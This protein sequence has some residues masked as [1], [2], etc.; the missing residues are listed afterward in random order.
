[1]IKFEIRMTK[2][3]RN[4]R[5]EIPTTNAAAVAMMTEVSGFG[6]LSTFGFRHSDFQP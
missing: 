3:K 4:S 5:P 6:H 1:M 2:S